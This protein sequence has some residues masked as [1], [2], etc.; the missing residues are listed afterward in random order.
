MLPHTLPQ[1]R[2]YLGEAVPEM[3][4]CPFAAGFVAGEDAQLSH[5][6]APGLAARRDVLGEGSGLFA[7]G[8]GMELPSNWRQILK[9]GEITNCHSLCGAHE[10][11]NRGG[12]AGGK[13]P[14]SKMPFYQALNGFLLKANGKK[15]Q[16]TSACRR[17]L[18][19]CRCAPGSRW[20]VP[21][22]EPTGIPCEIH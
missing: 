8:R 18:A 2:P 22:G 6:L 7:F 11:G 1:R 21:S 17:E 19:N 15:A 3:S 20:Q 9:K 16:G 12:K 4:L 13:A 5:R 14:S 10:G